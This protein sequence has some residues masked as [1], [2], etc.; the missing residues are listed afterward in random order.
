M[1]IIIYSNTI[2]D[3]V[4]HVK[5]VIDIL[6]H[7]K[8]YLSE[9]KLHFLCPELQIL[10][11]IIMD[12][13]IRMD[14]YKVDSILHWKTPTNHDLLCGFLGSVGYLADDIP[15]V[16]IPMGVLHKLTVD[17]VPFRW[18]FTEQCAFEDVKVLVQAAC[19]HHRVPLD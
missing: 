10:G 16:R 15:N 11:Q 6:T 14:P 18:G 2:K 19:N 8:L 1:F 13:G 12:E 7:E 5:T 4:E 3:H 17:T 9:K